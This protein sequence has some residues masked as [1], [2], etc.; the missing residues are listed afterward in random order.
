M[1][2]GGWGLTAAKIECMDGTVHA[3]RVEQLL[4]LRRLRAGLDAVEQRV[5][6][7]MAADPVPNLDG[8][9]GLDKQWVREDVACALR[10]SPGTAAGR[11]A[12]A[13]Q[14]V[15]RLPA[16]LGL[17]EAGEISVQHAHRLVDAVGGLP[18]AVAAAVEARV[19]P[20]APRQTVPQFVESLRRAV[21]A[22]DPRDPEQ[23]VE[24]AVAERRVVFTA[25]DDGTCEQWAL[26]P[27]DAAAA[28]RDVLEQAADQLKARDLG[29]DQPRTAD[30]RRA[31]ALVGLILT[32]AGQPDPTAAGSGLRPRVQVTVALSTLLE[33]DQQPG[34]LDG[35]GPIP[36]AAARA[37]AF[38]PTGTWRRPL[39]DDTGQLI[40]VSADSYRPPAGLAR[41]VRAAH[42]YCCFPGCRRRATSCE[43]DHILAR[44]DGGATHVDNLQPLCPRH[45]HLKHETGWTVSRNHDGTTTWRSPSGHT[46]TRPPD[47]LPIDTTSTA[48]D[49]P[50]F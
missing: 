47:P 20:R 42:P 40:A 5:L 4:L 28:V 30:Q 13:A 32:G 48:P 15:G 27:A 36:A 2:I 33:L 26:L 18:D 10:V 34:E 46:Y 22:L 38:D 23:V 35:H 11:L 37:L 8:T 19:L 43:L 1:D 14:L 45:H 24:D 17:L 7:E 16:T 39:T 44:T 6:A 29:S 41:H 50:P 31:D 3:G 9:P 25:Q 12:Q 49:P 21:L